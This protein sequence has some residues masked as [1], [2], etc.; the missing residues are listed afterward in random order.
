MTKLFTMKNI[1][2][3]LAV[4]S[5]ADMM[6]ATPL[7]HCE[8]QDKWNC[9]HLLETMVSLSYE[10]QTMIETMANKRK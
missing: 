7:S 2:S 5:K 8:Q 10:E 9:A 6:A 4:I 1:E 3:C